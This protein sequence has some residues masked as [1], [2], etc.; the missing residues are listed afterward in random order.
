MLFFAGKPKSWLAHDK[1]VEAPRNEASM[2]AYLFTTGDNA[3]M[4]KT[5]VRVTS[6][7]VVAGERVRLADFVIVALSASRS[8]MRSKW[9]CGPA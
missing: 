2:N 6:F 8:R 7:D 9:A 4:K 1:R 3:A 5:G